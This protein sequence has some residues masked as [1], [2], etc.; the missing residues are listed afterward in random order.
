[1]MRIGMKVSI[2][3]RFLSEKLMGEATIKFTDEEHIQKWDGIVFF[4][5]HG[6]LDMGRQVIKVIE[7]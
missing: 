5:F 7:E 4:G 6:K 1:M 3:M 2:S